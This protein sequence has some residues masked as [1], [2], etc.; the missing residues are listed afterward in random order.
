MCKSI[1]FISFY[2]ETN[3]N[4]RTNYCPYPYFRRHNLE[5]L[6]SCNEHSLLNLYQIDA[7]GTDLHLSVT[8]AAILSHPVG[9]ALNS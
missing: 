5:F 7:F 6:F 4:L 3:D 9:F 8:M 2:G 1:E